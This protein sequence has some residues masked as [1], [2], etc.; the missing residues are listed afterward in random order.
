M[1]RPSCPIYC[2]MCYSSFSA[3]LCDLQKYFSLGQNFT[4]QNHPSDRFMRYVTYQK[5]KGKVNPPKVI[6]I[7]WILTC[8]N[9]DFMIVLCYFNLNIYI[10][11]YQAP[12]I[13]LV[14]HFLK[15]NDSQ[16]QFFIF[17]YRHWAVACSYSIHILQ[18]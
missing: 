9:K 8:C 18:I 1:N 11:Q 16:A 14:L 17:N 4:A 3:F 2:I 5:Q 12:N 10:I 15:V 13:S 7:L 6:G